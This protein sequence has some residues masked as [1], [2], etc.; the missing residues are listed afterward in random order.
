[1]ASCSVPLINLRYPEFNTVIPVSI[2]HGKLG[3]HNISYKSGNLQASIFNKVKSFTSSLLKMYRTFIMSIT[4]ISFTIIL[5]KMAWL[6]IH[7]QLLGGI[8]QKRVP[9][10]FVDG[11]ICDGVPI[12]TILFRK[13]W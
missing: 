12:P 4:F 2:L 7:S 9:K 6:L 5:L 10:S 1:M 8:L 11:N 3:K 13:G